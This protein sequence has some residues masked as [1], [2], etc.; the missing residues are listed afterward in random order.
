MAENFMDPTF[1]SRFEELDRLVKKEEPVF[2]R[3]QTELPFEPYP[4]NVT[5]EFHWG[6]Y[7][8]RRSFP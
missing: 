2:H 8:I 1:L 4:D 5:R 6:C 7:D 3:V